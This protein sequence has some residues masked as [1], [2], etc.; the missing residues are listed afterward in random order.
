MYNTLLGLKFIITG[1][2]VVFLT[3]AVM[4]AAMWAAGR[5]LRGGGQK[6]APAQ[7]A[8]PESGGLDENEIAAAALA[9][10]HYL[11]EKDGKTVEFEPL[12]RWKA[13]GRIESL[14]RNT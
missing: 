6:R 5:L 4:S 3:L 10:H 1:L 9:I 14:E 8:A 2:V 11:S 12:S 7:K 13:H